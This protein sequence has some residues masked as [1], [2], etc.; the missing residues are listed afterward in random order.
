MAGTYSFNIIFQLRREKKLQEE[1]Q[2][3]DIKIPSGFMPTLLTCSSN[4]IVTT[5]AD[6]SN[7]WFHR[8]KF[9]VGVTSMDF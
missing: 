4:D 9:Q 6:C 2:G 3:Y 1:H 7:S 8:K 5:L